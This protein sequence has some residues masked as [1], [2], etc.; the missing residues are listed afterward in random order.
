MTI[1]DYDEV[2]DLWERTEG[3]GLAAGDE[4]DG[5][6]R[7][8]KRNPGLSFVAEDDERIIAAVMCGH[9][10]RRG[11]IG[12]LA[13]AESHRNNGLGKELVSRCLKKLAEEQIPICHIRV[14]T[15]NAKGI[16]FWEHLGW[17]GRTDLLIMA[18]ET[19]K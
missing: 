7:Y 6:D 1:D 5:I 16:R 17:D 9:N 3:I 12:H 4:R 19:S 13:I 8:L 11:D 14:F 2:C 18:C 15:E 10:G